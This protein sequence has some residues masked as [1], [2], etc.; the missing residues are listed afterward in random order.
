MN[1]Q[2]TGFLQSRKLEEVQLPKALPP[3]TGSSHVGNDGTCA[4]PSSAAA[5]QKPRFLLRPSR[6]RENG[7]S[8]GKAEG[9]WWQSRSDCLRNGNLAESVGH[10][11]TSQAARHVC[12]ISSHR[13]P[14]GGGMNKRETGFLQSRKLEGVQL[15]KPLPPE[16]G[17]PRWETTVLARLRIL[18]RPSKSPDFCCTAAVKERRRENCDS[19]GVTVYGTAIWPRV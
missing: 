6:R 14:G 8:Q 10:P 17:C 11:E 18:L 9:E 13:N 2:D 4:A 5:L 19:Q 3:R 15:P 7:G 1:K 16:A 12:T